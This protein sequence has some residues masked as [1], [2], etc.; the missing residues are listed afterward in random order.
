[1]T[2]GKASLAN[3]ALAFAFLIFV[4]GCGPQKVLLGGAGQKEHTPISFLKDRQTAKSEIISRLGRSQ[5]LENGRILIYIL[6]KK[7]RIVR[8][9]DKVRF[10]L[11]LVFEGNE[12]RI[13]EKHSLVRIR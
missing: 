6:D 10:H 12:G 9:Q 1:M 13:L 8:A 3:I 2:T 7:Y 5:E 4:A 11:V